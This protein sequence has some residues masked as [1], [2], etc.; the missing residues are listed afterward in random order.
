[1]LPKDWP[2]IRLED[3]TEK[4]GSGAT[5]K[6]GKESYRNSGISL[7]RSLNIYDYVFNYDNL[8]FI[9]DDQASKLR[10]V[11][12]EED[13]ILLNITGASVARCTI[14]PS[15][16]LPARVNQHVAIIRL[17]KKLVNPRFLLYT[18]NSGS[19][20]NYLLNIAQTGAT[21]E[22][23]TKDDILNFNIPVPPKSLQDRI[24]DILSA[25]DEL[26]DNNN[27]R[28][29]L[30]EQMAEQIYKEWFVR[31][32]FPGYE[33]T[34]LVKG[35]PEG[36]E[37]VKIKDIYN[38]SSGGTPSRKDYLNYQNGT[39]NWVKTGELKDSFVFDSEEKITDKGV[40]S[41][42]AKLFP[43]NTVI[44]A[45]YGATIG[46]LGILVNSAATN[47]A[48]CALLPKADTFSPWYIYFFL[49][50]YRAELVG[51]SM[52]AAQQNISQ[53]EI[54][55]VNILKPVSYVLEKF[56]KNIE[57]IFE[58]IK[59]LKSKN[60]VL[61][62]TRDLLLP[63]LISGQLSVEAVEQEEVAV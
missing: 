31:F 4:V 41:S 46:Q 39:I 42:S 53:N 18:L 33:N 19:Y 28:I 14:V 15:S 29:A 30:L 16:V 62:N 54:R 23:L 3:V 27:R 8:A 51:M 55:K 44:V 10:N 32:R 35:I 58:C 47:Q 20:K 9:S 38:T 49:K 13:D 45:M 43:S 24:A 7:I 25:Y 2:I 36:W 40:Q 60:T 5:P 48:C 50:N 26:I 6:G 1:M 63:R 59:T 56:N 12:V 37:V 21:R 22:A 52:G 57:P 11:I 17:K 61:K 34:K